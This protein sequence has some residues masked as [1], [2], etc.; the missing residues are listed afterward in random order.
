ME[1]TWEVY[2]IASTFSLL[3]V[4]RHEIKPIG[5]L[6]AQP[7]TIG[8]QPFVLDF[9]VIPLKKKGNDAILRRGWLV[10]ARSNHNWKKNTFLLENGARK[11]VVDLRTQ[12]VSKEMASESNFD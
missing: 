6:M 9:V 10:A 5:T 4:D 12:M 2:S 3:S 1:E 11:F 8:T 7:I